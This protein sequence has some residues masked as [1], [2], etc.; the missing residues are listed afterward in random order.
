M[1]RGVIGFFFC[2]LF[3]VAVSFYHES[4]FHIIRLGRL[5]IIIF[6]SVDNQRECQSSCRCIVMLVGRS[7]SM[8]QDDLLLIIFLFP[9]LF[10]NTPDFLQ[11]EECEL[12]FEQGKKRMDPEQEMCYIASKKM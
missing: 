12:E 5:C 9:N 2:G 10:T 7:C 6:M 4:D 3:L 1:G 8:T 11:T